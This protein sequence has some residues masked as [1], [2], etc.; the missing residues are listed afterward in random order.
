MVRR[1]IY[2]TAALATLGAPAM[3]EDPRQPL[4]RDLYAGMPRAEVDRRYPDKSAVLTDR[5]PARL[6]PVYR[7]GRL[8]E[9]VLLIDAGR[10]C[11]DDVLAALVARHGSP[12]QSKRLALAGAMSVLNSDTRIWQA[13]PILVRLQVRKSNGTAVLSYAR[14]S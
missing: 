9:V 14:G 7:R 2:V 11:S 12:G 4:W 3:A 13:G 5:C 8:A 10:R 1:L 6:D